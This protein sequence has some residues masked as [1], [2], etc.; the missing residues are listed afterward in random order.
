MVSNP[1]REHNADRYTH[2]ALA[3]DRMGTPRLAD[4]SPAYFG[5]VM[6][7]GIVS[8][9]AHMQGLAGIAHALFWLNV[10][11][12]A[13][14]WTLNLLRVM[15]YPRR[16][17][18]DVRDHVR[19]PGFFT[20]VAATSVLAS[21]LI[22]LDQNYAAAAVLGGIGV[23]LWSSTHPMHRFCRRSCRS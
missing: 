1:T 23:A 19:G 21:Q 11:A 22:V 6:A 13:L 4:F 12:Y 10:A 20:V 15:R 2:P 16:F 14:I 8:V 5:M 17:L 7:T 18:A 3:E 9:A